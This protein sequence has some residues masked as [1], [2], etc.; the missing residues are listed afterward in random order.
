M[1]LTDNEAI[2]ITIMIMK[3][4]LGQLRYFVFSH[5]LLNIALQNAN[6]IFIADSK[7]ENFF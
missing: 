3:L 1:K 6:L 7:L 2:M 4:I 5:Y